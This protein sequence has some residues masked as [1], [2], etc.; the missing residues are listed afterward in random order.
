[1]VWKKAV[2]RVLLVLALSTPQ[3]PSL[4]VTIAR[5]GLDDRRVSVRVKETAAVVRLCLS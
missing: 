3:P 5:L 1:M 2:T 4:G